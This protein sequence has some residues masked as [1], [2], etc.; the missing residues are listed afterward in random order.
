LD[1]KSADLKGMQAKPS[2]GGILAVLIL[3]CVCLSSLRGGEPQVLKVS[4][5]TWMPFNGEVGAERPGY[6]VELL[7]EIYEPQGVK[8]EYTTMPYEEAL[9]ATRE[10]RIDAVIGPDQKEGA[11]MLLPKQAMGRSC[12]LLLTLAKAD[13]NYESIR[14]LRGV[15]LGVVKGYT[16]WDVLDAH[17]AKGQGIYQAEGDEPLSVLITKLRRGDLTVV[18]ETESVL[19]WYLKLN[20]LDKAEFRAVYRHAPEPLYVAF[21]NNEKGQQLAGV[22]DKGVETLRKSGRLGKLLAS[23]GLRDWAE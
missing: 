20:K 10:A 18:A 14:S 19:A 13:F 3:L 4:A 6:V 12:I 5:D 11:G 2:P 16:Y 1:C 23:Y 15:Y 8:V 21:S 7:R 9:Q 17:I 22:Y